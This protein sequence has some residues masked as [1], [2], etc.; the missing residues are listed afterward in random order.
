VIA[1]SVSQRGREIGI[2]MALS[3]EPR[4]VRGLIFREV[5]RLALLGIVIGLAAAVA[6]RKRCGGGCLESA[7]GMWRRWLR[8]L[9]SSPSRRSPPPS[10]RRAV[11]PR[12]AAAV[13]PIEALR[14]E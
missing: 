1:Y 10:S 11:P 3:A 7:P 6:A 5:A 13:N 9:E 2:R 8:W 14:S 12:R 4:S